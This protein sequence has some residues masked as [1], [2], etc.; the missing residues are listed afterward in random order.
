VG[1]A[2]RRQ[3]FQSYCCNCWYNSKAELV[4][5]L[6]VNESRLTIGVNPCIISYVAASI[7]RQIGGRRPRRLEGPLRRAIMGQ[8]TD[9]RQC[10][11][12][13]VIDIRWGQLDW[14]WAEMSWRDGF[15]HD[16]SQDGWSSRLLLV[17]SAQTFTN[18]KSQMLSV[19][20]PGT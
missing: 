20:I 16:T 5:W 7:C 6:W 9:L 4:P 1:R 18:Q 10:L 17:V 8:F 15:A 12:C 2:H 11:G 13:F 3:E 19:Q 14:V